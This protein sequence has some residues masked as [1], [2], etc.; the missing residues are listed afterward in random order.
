[1]KTFMA[2]LSLAL[3][4]LGAGPLALAHDGVETLCLVTDLGRVNDGTFNQ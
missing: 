4:L 3:L 2:I 1:M